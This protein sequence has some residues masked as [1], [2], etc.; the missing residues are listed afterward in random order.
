MKKRVLLFSVVFLVFNAMA[1]LARDLPGLV[2]G[3]FS[4]AQEGHSPMQWIQFIGD[5]FIYYLLALGVY[6]VAC[7]YH[8]QKKY[9]V[10]II[11]LLLIPILAFF[12]G[13]FW[14][15]LFADNP[16]R[17][18]RYFRL[19]AI[20]IGMQVFFAMVFFLVRYA[21]HKEVQQVEL[22]LQ[23]RKAELSFLRS[24]I[25]PHFLFNNLNN[26]YALVYEQNP[27]A[28]SA[29]S[30]LSE[31]LRYMLYESSEMVT[32][33]TELSYIE[34]YISLQQI[35][36]EQPSLI[37]LTQQFSDKNANIPTLLLIPFIENAFKHGLI[38]FTECWLDLEIKTDSHG[39]S[40]RSSNLIGEKRKDK[41]GGIGL[42]NVKQRLELLYP[43]RHL[44]EITEQ[45]NR[46][47][48]SL[49]LTYGK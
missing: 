11:F 19:V 16:I 47:T 32:L 24:Q 4:I 33:K 7:R 20:P 26:I 48:V 39:L 15:G 31:L 36:F 12:S 46:F 6:L 10:L 40:F 21:Q 14:T 34:K 49:Q 28:L 29:L 25:N 45:D 35:R 27:Q 8:P 42:E 9:T 1:I 44:L 23:N 3:N 17:I 38:S 30:E 43:Q 5:S 37:K 18:S 13:L 22:Q 41:M 2:H